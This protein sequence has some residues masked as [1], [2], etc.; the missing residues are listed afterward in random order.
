MMWIL[1]GILFMTAYYEQDYEEKV[2]LCGS[3]ISAILLTLLPT[4]A[5]RYEF[6][7]KN[8]SSFA[9][10]LLAILIIICIQNQESFSVPKLFSF[11]L[12][13]DIL[14]SQC[15]RM[16]RVKLTFAYIF[17]NLITI[18]YTSIKF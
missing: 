17:M 9:V 6:V 10:S 11:I 12:G 15:F 8:Y 1:I 2:S 16:G 14:I 7:L 13:G 3:V 18:L 5:R 4:F